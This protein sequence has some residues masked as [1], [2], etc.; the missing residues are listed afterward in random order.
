LTCF[1]L[2]VGLQLGR[3]T[4]ISGNLETTANAGVPA[5]VI[6]YILDAAR[7]S[8]GAMAAELPGLTLRT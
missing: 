6:P 1:K 8:A 7:Q 3:W 2:V 5:T 4:Y